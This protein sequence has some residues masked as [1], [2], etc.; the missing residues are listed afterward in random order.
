MFLGSFLALG[1]STE[2]STSLELSCCPVLQTLHVYLT[3]ESMTDQRLLLVLESVLNSWYADV[4]SQNV[5]LGAYNEH[6]FT[7]QAFADL[8]H[9]TTPALE[10]WT[11]SSP[12]PPRTDVE[13]SEQRMERGVFVDLY[14]WEVWQDWWRMQRQ[15]R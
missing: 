5:H 2:V 12:T 7:R 9:T 10:G 6:E 15:E 13:A 1:H 11:H 4:G 8:L 3:Q 14:D